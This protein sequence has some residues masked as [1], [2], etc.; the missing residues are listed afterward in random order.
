[1]L[2]ITQ[3]LSTNLKGRC[4]GILW[5]SSGWDSSFQCR[6]Y[7][8][9]FWSGSCKI[10][11]ASRPKNWKVIQK[12]YCNKFNK[13][14]KSGPH[15]KKKKRILKMV[16]YH[17]EKLSTKAGWVEGHV[18]GHRASGTGRLAQSGGCP[19][20]RA[21]FLAVH[22]WPVGKLRWAHLC[23]SDTEGQLLVVSEC[24]HLRSLFC[25]S[26]AQWCP[27]VTPMDCSAPGFP[28]LHHLPEFAQTHVH[29]VGDAIQPA[30]PLSLYF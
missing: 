30:H 26:V 20:L 27:T 18:H 13:D 8:F 12:Q 17:S 9:A 1:M 16:H 11:Y 19:V 5:W 15:Q 10:P 14:F 23:L 22:L 28:V 29:W 3:Q 7:G 24:C 6:E 21:P 2:F 4:L 25:C